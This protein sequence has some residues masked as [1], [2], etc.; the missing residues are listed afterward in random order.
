MCLDSHNKGLKI[1]VGDVMIT[2]ESHG[3]REFTDDWKAGEKYTI[4]KYGK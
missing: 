3:L 4:E 2:H 1:G